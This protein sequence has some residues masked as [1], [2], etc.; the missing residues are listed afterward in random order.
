MS[1]TIIATYVG[2]LVALYTSIS[3]QKIAPEIV[4]N[5]VNWIFLGAGF[6]TSAIGFYKTHKK[7]KANVDNSTIK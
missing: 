2:L 5:L 3:G 7:A 1:K 4:N 6:V